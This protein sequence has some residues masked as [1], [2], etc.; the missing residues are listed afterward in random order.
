MPWEP[1]PWDDVFG[2]LRSAQGSRTAKHL[3][4]ERPTRW[5]GVKQS[6]LPPGNGGPPEANAPDRCLPG[7]ES[8]RLGDASEPAH[9]PLARYQPQHLAMVRREPSF[10]GLVAAE[11]VQFAEVSR[12][13]VIDDG[14]EQ[15]GRGIPPAAV[16]EPGTLIQAHSTGHLERRHGRDY[17]VVL[18][19]FVDDHLVGRAA[20]SES[21]RE[22]IEDGKEVGAASPLGP[23]EFAQCVEALEDCPAPDRPMRH[24]FSREALG[25]DTEVL[26]E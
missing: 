8:C 2:P 23:V 19:E 1:G 13:S 14:G 3:L 9:H 17:Q 26:A 12:T 25:G 4:M 10:I 7:L 22:P 6:G 5:R 11:E 21:G 24:S 18:P 15:E 16:G 20:T